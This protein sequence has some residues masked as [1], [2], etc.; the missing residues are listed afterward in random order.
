MFGCVTLASGWGN[1]QSGDGE[2]AKRAR[3]VIIDEHDAVCAGVESWLVRRNSG[4]IVVGSFRRPTQYLG[5][6]PTHRDTVDVVV[7]EIQENGQPPDL[8]RLQEICA[9]GPAVVVYSRV[10]ADE[11]ILSSIDLG[12]RCYVAKSD[13]G[14]HLIAALTRIDEG[15]PYQGPRMAAA[16]EREK[17]V[18]RLGL[19]IREKEVLR[20]WLRTDS[21]DDVAAALHIST[22]T[23]RTHLQRLRAKYDAV[24]RPAPTKTALLARAMEDGFVGLGDLQPRHPNG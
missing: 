4:L 2:L 21:K 19:S 14:E 22:A 6:L 8:D 10:I 11:V 23:V 3:I 18:G 12:V 16:L 24:G 1:P 13:G 9:A 15:K 20:A 5:W 17:A 7:A